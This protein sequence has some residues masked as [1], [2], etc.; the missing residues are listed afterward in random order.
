MSKISYKLANKI[1]VVMAGN[2]FRVRIQYAEELL[3]EAL[4]KIAK[5]AF[6]REVFRFITLYP[7]FIATSKQI[8]V[9]GIDGG[10]YENVYIDGRIDFPI[11]KRPFNIEVDDETISSL[12]E[13]AHRESDLYERRAKTCNDIAERIHECKTI[14]RLEKEFPEAY[15]VMLS[16]KSAEKETK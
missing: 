4:T 8:V 9:K 3:K 5:Q 16:I 10:K 1:A 14:A 6:P 11:P 7:Q 15:I 12:K 13:I 2:L